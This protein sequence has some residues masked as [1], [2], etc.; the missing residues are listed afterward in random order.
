MTTA[1]ALTLVAAFGAATIPAASAAPASDAGLYGSADP[2]YDGVWRQATALAGLAANR[3][4]PPAAAID[5]LLHQQCADGSFQAYRA[6]TTAPCAKS[7]PV[8]YAGPDTNQTAVA[9]LGLMALDNASVPVAQ[10]QRT[11]IVEAA[12]KAVTW[13]AKQQNANGGWAYYPGG[14]PDAPSTGLSL[15]ALMTQAP[16]R[17]V[18][19]YR[20]AVRFLG[21][22]SVPCASGGGIMYQPGSKVDELSTAQALVGV[23]GA[24]PVYGPRKAAVAA[25]CANTVEAKGT[26]Q[27]AS[28]LSGTGLL[29]SSTGTTDYADTA[30]AILD[31]VA[32]GKGRAA[33][34][35]A[36]A[37]LKA[38]APTIVNDPKGVNPDEA[39]L[40]LMVAAATGTKPAAFGGVNLVQALAGT[41]RK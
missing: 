23:V 37:A 10:K 9:V 33:I 5:W 13:L 7:D 12:D 15:A 29:T 16:N 3:V 4:A 24:I 34:A 38:A 22:L 35:K 18:P 31:L 21:T 11:Q 39:G 27:L 17:Q 40:L 41:L 25:P 14:T 2:T 36:T 28:A 20:A 26:S 19:A 30:T 1:V 6:D 8:N 32:A